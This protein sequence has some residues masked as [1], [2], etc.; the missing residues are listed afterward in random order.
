MKKFI[1]LLIFMILIGYAT[2]FVSAVQTYKAGDSI[3]LRVFCTNNGTYCSAGAVCNGSVVD[4]K[5]M[6]L[7]SNVNM[8]TSDYVIFNLTLNSSNSTVNGEYQFSAFCLDQGKAKADSFSFMI[9]PSGIEPTSSQGLMFIALLVMTSF[10]M[11]LCLYFSFA[12]DGNNLYDVGGNFLKVNFNK[13]IKQGLLFF[14]YLFFTIN[15]YFAWQISR[16]F[17]VINIA[18]DL[19]R[20]FFM[21]LEIMTLPIFIG[22]V[23]TALTKFVLD[24]RLDKLG[25][26]GLK[27]YGKN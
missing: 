21:F 22:F 3:D 1:S 17:L 19:L 20:S 6:I 5:G 16:N 11:C 4:P 15:I 18:T 14:S 8:T 9:T 2:C 13:Y 10:L 7:M 12:L 25:K 23:I 27:E 26:R 24:L